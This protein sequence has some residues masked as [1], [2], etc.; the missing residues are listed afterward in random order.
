MSRLQDSGYRENGYYWCKFTKNSEWIIG[1]WYFGGYS[2]PADW[3]FC[4]DDD[5]Y[6]D[7]DLFEINE[8][9]VKITG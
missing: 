6:D 4:G 5:S 8:N 3:C 1:C 9:R 2:R 7:I